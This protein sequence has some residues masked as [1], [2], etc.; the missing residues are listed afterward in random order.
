MP[1]SFWAWVQCSPEA[2][3]SM[4]SLQTHSTVVSF[5]KKSDEWIFNSQTYIFT[6]TF[7]ILR[8]SYA[9]DDHN[10]PDPSHRLMFAHWEVKQPYGLRGLCHSVPT[11][12]EEQAKTSQLTITSLIIWWKAQLKNQLEYQNKQHKLWL[13]TISINVKTVIIC[14]SFVSVHFMLIT[15]RGQQ[16]GSSQWECD[17]RQGFAEP[18]GGA[19]VQEKYNIKICLYGKSLK[20]NY[21]ANASQVNFINRRK[22][23]TNKQK[24]KNN[25]QCDSHYLCVFE[26]KIGLFFKNRKS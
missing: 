9:C 11:R 17:M 13:L 10:E 6:M 23:K 3:V 16:I 20:W 5:L 26:A 12:G 24:M 25:I 15:K 19:V 14:K 4:T 22:S 7:L 21:W 1:S 8:V 18:E 2:I